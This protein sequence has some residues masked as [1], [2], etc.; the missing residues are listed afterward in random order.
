[1]KLRIFRHSG[2][3]FEVQRKLHWWYRWQKEGKF[4]S[5]VEAAKAVVRKQQPNMKPVV[6]S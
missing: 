4:Y 5:N 3:C 1:M 2:F 6:V